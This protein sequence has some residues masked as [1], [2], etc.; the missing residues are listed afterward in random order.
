ME[1]VEIAKVGDLKEGE[2]K[3][4][5]VKGTPIMLAFVNGRY[6]AVIDKCTHQG[7]KLSSGELEHYTI[8]CPWHGSQ[9]DIRTGEVI[10]LPAVIALKTYKVEVDDQKIYILLKN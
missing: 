8:E 1:K 5:I 3:R 4:Y 7:S 9:F 10:S 6:Y 2:K